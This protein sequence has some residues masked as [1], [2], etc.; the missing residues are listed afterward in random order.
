GM[1]AFDAATGK[2]AWKSGND[3]AS[4]A[5]P[6]AV[7]AGGAKQV[8]FLTSLALVGVDP[9][10]GKEFWRVPFRDALQESATTPLAAGN[11][12]VGSSVTLGSIALKMEAK[13][14][15]PA[16]EQVWKKPQLNCYFSTPVL[17]GEEYLYMLNGKLSINPT[18]TLRC[19]ELSTGNVKWEKPNVGK[20]HAALVRTGDNKLLMLDDGGTLTLF[21]HDPSGYKELAKSKVCGATWAHPAVAD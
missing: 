21:A 14:G 4:Y 3:G 6:I 18:I 17:V 9:D 13:G 2:T 20:Y 5:S 1:V 12:L 8:V 11:L 16:V 19:V 10:S 7:E 15:K